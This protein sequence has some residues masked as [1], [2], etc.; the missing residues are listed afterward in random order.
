MDIKEIKEEVDELD[1]GYPR[2]NFLLKKLERLDELIEEHPE[3]KPE[4]ERDKKEIKKLLVKS[5][6]EKPIAEYKISYDSMGEGIEPLYFWTLDFMRDKPPGGLGLDVS[7]TAEGFEASAGSGFFGEMGTRAGVMQ[8]RAMKILETVNTVLRSIVNLIYDLKE[9]EMRLEIYDKIN[10]KKEDEREAGELALK[11]VWMDQ[12]D[13]KRGRGSINMLSQQLDFVTL[14]DAFMGANSLS[15]INRMDLNKRVKNILL[16]KMEEYL[17][18]KKIS[19]RELR[20]RFQI[21]KNYLR[22]QVDS[23]RIYVKWIKPYLK[24]AQKLGMKEFNTPDI[25]ASF[26]NMQIE[27]SLFG[28]EEFK[29]EKVHESYAKTNFDTK[30]FVGLEIDFNFRT[31]PAITKSGQGGSHYIQSGRTDISFNSFFL[32]EKELEILED[33]E[34]YEDMDLIHNLT[35]V[36][37]DSLQEDLDHFLKKPED[38]EEKNNKKDKKKKH[39]IKSPFGNLKEGFKE[40][41]EPIE[42]MG[43]F[44]KDIFKKEPTS[45]SFKIKKIQKAAES[46]AKE[47]CYM[48]YDIYKK[49]HGMMTW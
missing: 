13:I 29:P 28:K 47:K 35:E 40:M 43:D 34:L 48:A 46:E 1:K 27:L 23:L 41:V 15:D 22:T 39:K 30:F 36:S 16:R 21:E 5:I 17:E 9:F 32:R 31:V 14:R 19:E 20:K 44:F 10:S 18:W 33:R 37:L 26:N 12:V 38:E 49:A 25:V 2:R 24:A 45:P 8:D 42:N 4:L 3:D 6:K 11:G 7:K